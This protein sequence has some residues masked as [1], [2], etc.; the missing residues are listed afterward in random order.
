M[1]PYT[2]IQEPDLLP[3]TPNL[4]MCNLPGEGGAALSQDIFERTFLLGPQQLL[5]DHGVRTTADLLKSDK[6]GQ[7]FLEV[8][9]SKGP[10][11]YLKRG[12]HP[13]WT[14]CRCPDS[15]G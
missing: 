13:F 1:T 9:I 14:D 3:P 2:Q 4:R 15:F 7:W 6:S 8:A 11:V 5:S 12:V 10:L